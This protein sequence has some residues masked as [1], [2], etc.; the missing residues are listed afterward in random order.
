[1]VDVFPNKLEAIMCMPH[2]QNNMCNKFRKCTLPLYNYT[3]LHIHVFLLFFLLQ[4]AGV[5]LP[6]TAVKVFRELA[7]I[8]A[9]IENQWLTVVTVLSSRSMAFKTQFYWKSIN[10]LRNTCQN[11]EET[12]IKAVLHI[13]CHPHC[14]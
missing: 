11:I 3:V 4:I 14:A 10:E 8:S 5:M 2:G 9:H 12:Q 1:M 13:K 7:G 6:S